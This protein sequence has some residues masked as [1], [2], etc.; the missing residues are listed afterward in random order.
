MATLEHKFIIDPEVHQP[1]GA[2]SAS[3]GEV[4]VSLGAGDTEFRDL[5]VDDLSDLGHDSASEGDIFTADGVGGTAW[6]NP[7]GDAIARRDL[8]ESSVDI[9]LL[10]GDPHT[11][12]SYTEVAGDFS[13]RFSVG[14]FTFHADG[15]LIV[16]TDGYYKVDAWISISSS[17]VSSPVIALNASQDGI[18]GV[19][20][21][22]VVLSKQKTAGDIVTIAG[23]GLIFFAAGTVVGA[24]LSSSGDTTVTM[25]EGVMEI[26]RVRY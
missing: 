4:L 23:Y 12:G 13:E 7:V 18:A 15:R 17:S 20:T 16:P 3:G 22:P 21:S 26:T 24:A 9:V 25:Y 1:R 14:G 5:V 19:S 6:Q 11:S 2:V 8:I 10:A